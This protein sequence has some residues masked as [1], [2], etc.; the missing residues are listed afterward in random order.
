MDII[1]LLYL[2]HE[3]LLN[4]FYYRKIDALESENLCTISSN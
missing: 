1:Y 3:I 2:H 4:H